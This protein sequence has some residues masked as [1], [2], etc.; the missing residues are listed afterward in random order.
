MTKLEA[1]RH[2]GGNPSEEKMKSPFFPLPINPFVIFTINL[3]NFTFTLPKLGSEERRVT[4]G[5]LNRWMTLGKKT[6]L[7]QSW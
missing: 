3:H 2:E 5:G 1:A 4:A 6:L 7:H